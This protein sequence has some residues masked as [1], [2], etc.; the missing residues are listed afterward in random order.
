MRILRR[1]RIIKSIP[2]GGQ[3]K[4][5]SLHPRWITNESLLAEMRK[6]QLGTLRMTGEI[7]KG[8]RGEKY[9]E[10]FC[11]F[12]NQFYLVASSNIRKSATK[13]CK[14]QRRRKYFDNRALILGERY[15][16]MLQRCV[17]SENKLFKNYG[18]RGVKKKIKF[19]KTYIC[20]NF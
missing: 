10:Y 1:R 6:Y 3:F 14:C 7:K 4:S 15:D 2:I 12:C 8:K 9:I 5:G 11:N 17:A 19:V 18:G 13:N 20:W 16:A